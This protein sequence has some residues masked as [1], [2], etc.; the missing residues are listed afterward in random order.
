MNDFL[1]TILRFKVYEAAS[2]Q[3]LSYERRIRGRLRKCPAE[4]LLIETCLTGGVAVH[5]FFLWS[6]NLERTMRHL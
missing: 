3:L 6:L 1:M 4:I 2:G 5:L